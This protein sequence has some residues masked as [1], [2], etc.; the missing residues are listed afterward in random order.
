MGD[1]FL[2]T[3]LCD[4]LGI[5]Y[6]ILQAGMG[7][8][9]IRGAVSNPELAAAVSEAGGLGVLG[10]AP[11]SVEEFAHSVKV[12]KSLTSKPV[13]VNL[14]FPGG[15]AIAGGSAQALAAKIPQEYKEFTRDIL[16]ELKVEE[17]ERKPEPP[18]LYLTREVSL[19]KLE[20]VLEEKVSVLVYSLGDPGPEVIDAAHQAG[21]TVIA[22]AGTVRQAVRL[23]AEGVDAVVAV[24][25]E[26]GGH[27][28]YIGTL[29]LTPQVVD[30]VRPLPALAGGGI[31]D[32]RG[33]VAALAL[34]AAGVWVGTRFMLSHESATV[35]WMKQLALDATDTSTVKSKFVS[36]K[37]N[38]HLRSPWDDAWE[39]AARKPLPIPLQG[40][41]FWDYFAS[42]TEARAYEV[43][44]ET[45]G[46]GVGLIN[47]IR[48]AKQ[49]LED[50][51]AEAAEVYKE[52]G[53][54]FTAG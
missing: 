41:L 45:M 34:G 4:M 46:Q 22:L 53:G 20:I 23:K 27:S 21:I 8:N 7:G 16:G 11:W 30:A 50:M 25:Y 17:A 18:H 33:L 36:G 9:A 2:H 52:L 28:G 37:P 54:R 15:D 44:G 1:T 35:P 10:G 19:R 29:A 3:E 38:R 51:V 24:G 12:L 40:L 13:G 14:V 32:G 6:P 47:E 26:A 48:P 5:R 43:S 42:V 31:S 39:E 49:I